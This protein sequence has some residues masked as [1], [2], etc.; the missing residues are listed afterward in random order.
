MDRS[1][2]VA[3]LMSW[4]E[5]RRSERNLGGM[6]RYGIKTSRAFGVPISELRPLARVLGRDHARA[7][8]LWE[9][10]WREARLLAAFTAEK[11][12][13]TRDEARAWAAGFDSWDVVD[14]VC[15]LFADA[16]FWPELVGE[17]AA[18]EREFVRRAGFVTLVWACVH[19][20]K[21]PDG[22]FL[23][24]LPLIERHSG[25][26]RNFV[27]KAVNWALRQI[28]KRSAALHGPCLDLA[29]KLAASP[30]KTARWIGSDA[31]R[32]LDGEKVIQRLGL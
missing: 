24:W 16:D 30:D 27:K 4:L 22:T 21:E 31:V 15:D 11:H 23:A 12:K 7:L 25:D 9:T 13:L 20:K 8:A 32:E 26:P 6:A 1:A 18:D 17:F 29:R 19:R 3:D 14:G 2:T 5:Q 28:G 10:G